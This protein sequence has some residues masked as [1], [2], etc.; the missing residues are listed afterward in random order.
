[1]VGKDKI[2]FLEI[3]VLKIRIPEKTGVEGGEIEITVAEVAT[4]RIDAAEVR[5]DDDRSGKVAIDHLA[6]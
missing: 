2:S 5:M 3:A 6:S 1:M 4:V